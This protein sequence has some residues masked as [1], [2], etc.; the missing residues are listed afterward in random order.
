MGLLYDLV[1]EFIGKNPKR[2]VMHKIWR[3]ERVP[4]PPPAP[5]DVAHNTLVLIA[6]D[7]EGEEESSSPE[8]Y[9]RP[10]KANG[11]C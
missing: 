6:V 2:C 5:S 8:G 1:E 10:S 9:R 3:T 7:R 11:G 4:A